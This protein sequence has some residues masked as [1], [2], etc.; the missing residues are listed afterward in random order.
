MVA[1]ILQPEAAAA[2][3]T[4]AATLC[5]DSLVVVLGEGCSLQQA[6]GCGNLKTME[7]PA[8]IARISASDMPTFDLPSQ[9]EQSTSGSGSS[10]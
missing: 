4:V 5:S 8:P 3:E 7:A 2:K 9:A 1:N 10:A 6:S